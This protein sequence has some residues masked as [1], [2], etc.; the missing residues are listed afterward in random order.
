MFT[1]A[2]VKRGAP[3]P[4]LKRSRNSV[5]TQVGGGTVPSWLDQDLSCLPFVSSVLLCGLSSRKIETAIHRA[6]LFYI[7]WFSSLGCNEDVE[8]TGS[9][10]LF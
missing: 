1:G 4:T 6:I 7:L 10:T 3:R 8:A 2:L 9:N 5:S